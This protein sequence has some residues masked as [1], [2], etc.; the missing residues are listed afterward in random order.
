MAFEVTIEQN[1]TTDFTVTLK[2]ATGGYLQLAEADKVR[3]KQGRGT[4]SPDL[5]IL[6][7]TAT[8][9]SSSVTIDER[10]DGEATHCS[11]TVRLAQGDTSDLA[12]S[13]AAE[14]GV[15]DAGETT[16][17]DALKSAEKGTVHVIPSLGGN[18]GT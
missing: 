5:D 2:T 17:V 3:Y 4:D 12:G 1:R 15:V 14:I 7:G 8:S 10:G 16:P 11:I 6:S 13:Y 18:V 9:N